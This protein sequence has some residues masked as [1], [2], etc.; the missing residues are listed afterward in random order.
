MINTVYVKNRRERNQRD[1]SFVIDPILRNVFVG[2]P[3]G[4]VVVLIL[5]SRVVGCG[6]RIRQG[7]FQGSIHGLRG[8][9]SR[10]DVADQN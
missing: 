7:A 8:F 2:R 5:A 10:E 3:E 9:Q 6:S 1:R 4:T